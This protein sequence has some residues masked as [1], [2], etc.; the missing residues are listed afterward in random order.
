MKLRIE[1]SKGKIENERTGGY[2]K[3]YIKR[4]KKK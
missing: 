1:N 4:M 3:G 2:A